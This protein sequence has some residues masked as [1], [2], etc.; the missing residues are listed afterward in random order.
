MNTQ[1]EAIPTE[2]IIVNRKIILKR[3]GHGIILSSSSSLS[4]KNAFPIWSIDCACCCGRNKEI[5]SVVESMGISVFVHLNEGLY[6]HWYT[7]DNSKL[8]PFDRFHHYSTEEIARYLNCTPFTLLKRLG[9]RVSVIKFLVKHHR[10]ILRDKGW[11]MDLELRS[12]MRTF[13]QKIT[14]RL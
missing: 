7:T 13:T 12:F 3:G 5:Q 10:N 2:V 9:Y 4:P 1:H 14:Y 8:G 6:S 11:Q